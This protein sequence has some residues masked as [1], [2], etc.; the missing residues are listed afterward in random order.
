MIELRPFQLQLKTAMFHGG[1][2]VADLSI[3]FGRSYH[4]VRMWVVNGC[5]PRL[6]PSA[7]EAITD[8]ELLEKAVR[9]G[10]FDDLGS[11][12][13]RQRPSEIRRIHDFWSQFRSV[14]QRNPSK[15][16]PKGRRRI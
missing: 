10:A 2:T 11:I 16:G 9:D 14:P 7:E 6:P 5:T 1:L 4:T 3:W 12:P 13:L 15:R 8:M